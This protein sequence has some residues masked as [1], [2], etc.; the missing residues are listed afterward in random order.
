MGWFKESLA[1]KIWN[2]PWTQSALTFVGAAVLDFLY[3]YNWAPPIDWNNVLVS[4]GGAAL[5]AL[6]LYL[7]T[8]PKDR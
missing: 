2:S 5:L 4:A 8:A 1:S 6:R 3:E 7:K